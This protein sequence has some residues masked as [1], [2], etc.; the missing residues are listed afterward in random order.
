MGYGNVFHFFVKGDDRN[1]QNQTENW[2]DFN[3]FIGVSDDGSDG[4]NG[5][6]VFDNQRHRRRE[7]ATDHQR[8]S[9]AT[10]E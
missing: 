8:Q 10:G 7:C 5:D 2:T 3:G 9:F 1:I 4:I 6:V